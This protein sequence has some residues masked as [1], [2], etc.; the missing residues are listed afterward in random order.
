MRQGGFVGKRLS[1]VTVM[2]MVCAAQAALAQTP[3]PEEEPPPAADPATAT[4]GAMPAPPEA[5][6]LPP[7]P[8]PATPVSRGMRVGH[9]EMGMLIGG[10]ALFGAGLVFLWSGSTH[11]DDAEAARTVADHDRIANRSTAEYVLGAVGLTAGVALSVLAVYRIHKSGHETA[12]A[13][14]PRSGGGSLVLERSW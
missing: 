11:A 5:T 4:A 13:F 14:Q 6:P 8:P 3:S 2:G 7:P 12:V 1:V 10:G 9:A